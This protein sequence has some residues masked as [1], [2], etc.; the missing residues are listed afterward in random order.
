MDKKFV[1]L[2]N[3][4]FLIEGIEVIDDELFEL[5]G[6]FADD[7]SSGLGCDCGCECSKGDGCGCGCDEGSGCGCGC[8]SGIG[9]SCIVRKK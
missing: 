1:S 9:C 5:R 4:R 6:G 3:A 7:K 2:K 8:S